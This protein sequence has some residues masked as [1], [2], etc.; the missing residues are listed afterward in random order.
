MAKT[1]IDDRT[2]VLDALSGKCSFTI[3]NTL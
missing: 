1:I 2:I 3:A